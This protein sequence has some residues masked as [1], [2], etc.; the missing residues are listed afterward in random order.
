MENGKIRWTVLL[1]SIACSTFLL[2]H[3]A[4]RSE[5]NNADTGTHALELSGVWVQEVGKATRPNW[6]DSQGN[7]LEKLPLT[8]CD[9]ERFTPPRPPPATPPAPPPTSPTPI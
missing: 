4:T 9:E 8:A 6:I 1:A 7:R 5:Q 2:A 3:S